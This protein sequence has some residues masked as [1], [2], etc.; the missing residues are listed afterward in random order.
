MKCLVLAGGSGDALWPLSRKNYPKQF[1]YMKEGRSLFQEAIARNLP[2][3]DE[4]YIVTNKKYKYIV[5]G[6]LQAFQG[7]KYQCFLEETGR[8][9]GP[10]A[11]VVCMCMSK[12]EQVLVVSTDHMIGEGDY[13]GTILKA[14]QLLNEFAMVVI[15]CREGMEGEAVDGGHNYFSM[16]NPAGS[17]GRAIGFMEQKPDDFTDQYLMDSGIFCMRAGSYLE[18]IEENEPLLFEQLESKTERLYVSGKDFIISAG[19]MKDMPSISIGQAV[20]KKWTKKGRIGLVKADF[21]WSRLLNMEVV[22]RVAE[23]IDVGPS[24]LETCENVSVINREKSNLIIGNGL[25]DMLIVNTKDATYISK[26]GESAS[27]KEIMSRHYEEQKASFDEGDVFYTTWGIKETLNRSQG[28]MVKKLTIFPGRSLSMHK[29]EKRSEHWSVVSG[30]ATITMSGDTKEYS[31]NESI[32][33]P[34]NTYHKI[35]NETAKDLIV[36]EV[37]IGE[38]AGSIEEDLLP[39]EEEVL[40]LSPAYKDYLW[41]GNRLKTQFYKDSEKEILAESWELSTHSA[42]QSTISQ[43]TFAGLTLKEYIEKAGKKVL[44]WK[45]EPFAEFP[46]LIKFIDAKKRLSIQI[47]PDDAYALSVEGEY[48]KNEMWYILDAKE[49]AFVYLGFNREVTEAECRQRI[50]EGNLEEVLKKVPVKPGDVVFVEAGT[51]HAINEGI[52]VLEIQQSSNATYRLYDYNRT[53]KNGRRRELHLD[54]AFANMKW[55]PYNQDTSPAGKWE[56]FKG[57]KKLLL[58]QCKYFSAFLYEVEISGEINFDN[59]SFCSVI[60]LKGYGKLVAA[61][62]TLDFKPG[63]SFF[64]PAGKKIIRIEGNSSFV[65]SHV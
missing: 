12:E 64:V 15:G 14:S 4:F 8:Q 63:D 25:S 57:Y 42:G 39:Q 18:A 6:Q 38:S 26:K 31:R 11:A 62:Q 53:D 37:S 54:K 30:R 49:D 29:H 65:I 10:A 19:F 32:Y 35:S 36:I 13:N 24:I 52:L 50:L 43:G 21:V 3:C 40:R 2:F 55:T 5:S 20:F 41:G 59:S 1:I 17:S 61:N 22:T 56:V 34:I 45:C 23:E 46:L 28:Y 27:I 33:V 44:G 47:H 58:G 48:G 16:E 7:L 51:I 9:T 60:V